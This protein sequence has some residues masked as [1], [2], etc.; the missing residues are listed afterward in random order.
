[1]ELPSSLRPFATQLQRSMRSAE[2]VTQHLLME[3]WV[4]LA[5]IVL[6]LLYLLRLAIS[7]FCCCCCVPREK[8]AAPIAPEA[9]SAAQSEDFV[10]KE[11]LQ[12]AVATLSQQLEATNKKVASLEAKLAAGAA[13]AAPVPATKSPPPA[14]TRPAAVPVVRTSSLAASEMS[15]TAGSSHAEESWSSEAAAASEPAK[16]PPSNGAPPVS[17]TRSPQVGSRPLASHRNSGTATVAAAGGVPAARPA[18]GG[19]PAAGG[20]GSARGGSSSARGGA[21]GGAH[22]DRT[23]K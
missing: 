5:C 7:R 14:S 13:K 9:Y 6:P 21:Q 17:G 1:M 2:T 20:G 11:E 19:F 16:K 23:R 10:T 4:M 18:R 12:R 15:E 22:T 3:E 8:G